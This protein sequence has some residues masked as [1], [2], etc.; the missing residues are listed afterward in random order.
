MKAMPKKNMGLADPAPRGN[1][2][3]NWNREGEASTGFEPVP[4]IMIC[5]HCKGKMHLLYADFFTYKKCANCGHISPVVKI[6]NR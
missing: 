4:K 6:Y 5:P 3:R 2:L 1:Y